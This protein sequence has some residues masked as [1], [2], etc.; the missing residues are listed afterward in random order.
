LIVTLNRS[1]TIA[2]NMSKKI[3][4][5]L[6][7]GMLT[8]M[9]M[10]SFQACQ[11]TYESE[12]GKIDLS[13][14]KRLYYGIK[15]ND[16]LCG[17]AEIDVQPAERD[18]NK[19]LKI[20]DKTF[21]MVSALG[22]RFNSEIHSVAY[23]DSV[24]GRFYY[25]EIHI[26]QGPTEFSGQASVDKD[27]ITTKSTLSEKARKIAIEP[28]V[29]LRNNQFFPFLIRDFSDSSV[30]E[31][32]YRYFEIKDEEVQETIFK[33]LGEETLDL[34]GGKF[35]ALVFEERNMKNGLKMKWWL[36]K[37]KGYLL[38]LITSRGE[39]FLAD[40]G[41]RDRI[42]LS[43]M[44]DLILQKTN[45]SIADFQSI[46]YMKVKARLEPSGLNITSKGLNVPG[47][48][49]E[50]TVQ[51]NLIEGI[52]EIEHHPYDGEN[53]PPFPPNLSTVDS[54]QAFLKRTDI[55][56]S[57]DPDLI[58]K[59]EDITSGSQNSW[60]A[61]VRLSQWVADSIGYAIPG[62]MTARNTYDI[63][64]GECGAHSILLAAFCRAIGIPARMVWGCMYVPNMGGAFGQHAWTEVY[65]GQAGWVPVD[66]T[67]NEPDYVDSG[68]LRLGHFQSLSIA[69]NA[70]E[71]EILEYHLVSD[72]VE[73]IDIERK[74][75]PYLG[76]YKGENPVNV[77]V[78][79][80]LLTVDIPG[81]TM[82]ALN[83]PDE[84]GLWHAKISKSVF[85]EFNRDKYGAV[86]EMILHQIIPFPRKADVDRS[87][88]PNVPENMAPYPGIYELSQANADFRVFYK[89]GSLT[90][91][92]PLEKRDIKLRPPDARGRWKDEFNKNEIMFEKNENGKVD[93][94]II[95]SIN[96]FQK[97][98]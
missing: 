43:T 54:V 91:H 7:I 61:A 14:Q 40:S 70:K 75:Q 82:L 56:E 21:V 28:D 67:T 11:K 73:E 87:D 47:Q 25:Q 15:I 66:A 59:A 6:I 53:A 27:T 4:E 24:T 16:V 49:F 20:D 37:D 2:R 79:N 98:D 17:Y 3:R 48:K 13:Q 31:K 9:A 78:Q 38:K 1:T 69:L 10:V 30:Q 19:L 51:D 36:D 86:K 29:V 18:G 46:S 95:D 50:G 68:H 58:R 8:I 55:M 39:T 35:D 94:M 57:N 71:M 62:G 90:I 22:S 80:N 52:F 45:V 32:T 23:V 93:K 97:E 89:S 72:S 33:R 84:N 83:D 12:D 64:K 85:I 34:A 26:K 92:N 96:R 77:M 41:V 65:M 74:Y 63:R 76:K 44:D 60:E 5:N 81:K 42:R 88:L